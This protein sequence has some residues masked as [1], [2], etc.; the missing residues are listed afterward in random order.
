VECAELYNVYKARALV[1]ADLNG[2]ADDYG[3][4]FLQNLMLPEADDFGIP[5]PSMF[6]GYL[7]T[8]EN[9][10]GESNLM[11]NSAGMVRPNLNPCP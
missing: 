10:L 4:C 5:N 6:F 9:A 8:S 11:T 2:L 3:I 7:V 1:D